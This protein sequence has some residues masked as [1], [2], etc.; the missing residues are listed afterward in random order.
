MA[1]SIASCGKRSNKKI[2][3]IA[4]D[5]P[6]YNTNIIEIDT[7]VEKGRNTGWLYQQFIGSDDS[8]YI[9]ETRGDYDYP[10]DDEINWDTF[11]S[12]D[13]RFDYIAVA[14]RNTNQTVTVI[15][16]YKDLAINEYRILD[17]Y[18][19][20]GMITV[21]TNVSERDY[22]PL[23]GALLDTR[24]GSEME[25][26]PFTNTYEFGDYEVET[27]VFQ[28]EN[29]RRYSLVKVKAPDGKISETKFDKADKDNYV[30]TPMAISDTKILLPVDSGKETVYYELDLVT[31]ELAVGDPK[32]YEWMNDTGYF[33]SPVPGPEGMIYGRSENGISRLNAKIKNVEEVFNYD[34]CS[35]N[36]SIMESFD[37]VECTQ[38]KFV[39]CG[40]YDSSSVYEGRKAD[41]INIIEITKAEKNPHAGKIILEL[42]L[43]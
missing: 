42:L 23:T 26:D 37:L 2:R 39:L 33:I 5:S 13:Y 41:K 4:E 14:D 31:N 6:W 12:R 28:T 19:L 40:R 38:D 24:S 17:V 43:Q 27:I 1:L 32:E 21:K 22:D 7:G 10:P 11:D 8:C 9:I 36:R 29:N 16:I 18:Y 30:Q 34:W 15:D 35:L 3:K 20:N 25:D